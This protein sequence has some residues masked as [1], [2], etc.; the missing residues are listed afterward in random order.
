MS[1]NTKVFKMRFQL[2]VTLRRVANQQQDEAEFKAMM[3]KSIEELKKATE[4]QPQEATAFNNLGL[5][6][7]EA[8]RLEDAIE[9]YGKAIAFEQ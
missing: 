4:I 7:F 1:D 8:G 2:G 5:S 9:C 6:L 3:A